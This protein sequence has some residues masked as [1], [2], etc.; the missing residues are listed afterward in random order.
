MRHLML[1]TTAALLATALPLAAQDAAPAFTAPGTELAV[2]EKAV[3]PYVI[4][5][6]PI[7]PIE[8]AITAIEEGTPEDVA[9]FT[10]PPELADARPIFV[11]Y[12]YTNVSDQDL[13]NQ[14]LAGLTA[15]DDRNTEH[16]KVSIRGEN[17]PKCPRP[18]MSDVGPGKTAEGC[19]LY[20]IHKDGNLKAALYKGSPREKDGVDAR[21]LYADP[22]RWAPG[23]AP[24]APTDAP[25]G[26]AIVP[27]N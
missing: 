10:I 17:V 8:F 15:V 16:M 27:V 1:A 7:V 22:I 24:T 6:G 26:G 23:A 12:S 11:R 3:V 25:A 19:D 21:P 20:M 4:P 2:G 14:S 13:S 9:A 18:K 5:N